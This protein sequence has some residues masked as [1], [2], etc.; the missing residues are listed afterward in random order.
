M[1]GSEA[2]FMIERTLPQ[3][4]LTMR[5]YSKPKDRGEQHTRLFRQRMDIQLGSISFPQRTSRKLIRK[6]KDSQVRPLA[7][8]MKKHQF[9]NRKEAASE[10][11]S[12]REHE[13]ENSLNLW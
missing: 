11:P 9:S 5:R 3:N 1:Q 13:E 7:K 8:T 4:N 6:V 12:V 10:K 2:S